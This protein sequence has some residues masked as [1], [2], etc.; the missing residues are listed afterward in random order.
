MNERVINVAMNVSM[1][2]VV[3]RRELA[4]R[5]SVSQTLI[6]NEQDESD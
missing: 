5:K 1:A 3:Y 2:T 4:C 6:A